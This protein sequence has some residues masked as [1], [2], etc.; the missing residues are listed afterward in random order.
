LVWASQDESLAYFYEQLEKINSLEEIG[1]LELATEWIS[2]LHETVKSEFT[3]SHLSKKRHMDLARLLG[4]IV[5][6]QLNILN[7]HGT[8]KRIAEDAPALINEMADYSKVLK[9]KEFIPLA[10]Y[11]WGVCYYTLFDYT[12]S[13]IHYQKALTFGALDPNCE[14]RSVRTLAL[15]FAYLQNRL[16]FAKTEKKLKEMIQSD[17]FTFTWKS[18]A[19]EG[20]ARG[21]AILGKTNFDNTLQ[22]GWNIYKTLNKQEDHLTLRKLQLSRTEIECFQRINSRSNGYFE[23][24]GFEAL[25]EARKYGFN[26]H[27]KQLWDLLNTIL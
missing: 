4:R 2:H 18:E 6:S 11:L 9:E 25:R 16:C 21:Q 27:A 3:E 7:Q 22:E 12:K 20:L 23:D 1:E 19:L 24:I 10:D 8:L 17:K 13:A 15:D 5:F 14:L 26:R